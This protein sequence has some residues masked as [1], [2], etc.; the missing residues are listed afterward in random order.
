MPLSSAVDRYP[1]IER[2]LR[3]RE[4]PLLAYSVAIIIIA[5]ATALRMGV[6]GQ[7]IAGVPFITFYPA[8][9]IATLLVGL[10]LG[11]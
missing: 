5:I 7:L 4:K 6:G 11:S 3:V 10:G 8:I 1:L 9:I 2:A